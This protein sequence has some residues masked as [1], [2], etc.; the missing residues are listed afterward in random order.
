MCKRAVEAEKITTKQE[1]DEIVEWVATVDEKLV[2]ADKEVSRLR[3]YQIGI[4]KPEEQK[5]QGKELQ[6]EHVHHETRMK[7]QPELKA[8]K[9][10]DNQ[11]HGKLQTVTVAE[12]K[13]PKV[14]ITKFEGSY[15]DWPRFRGQFTELIDKSNVHNMTKF[16]YLR[17]LLLPK[18]CSGVTV[19]WRRL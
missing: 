2:K 17:Q 13:S 10:T 6:F 18:D 12:A 15:Q 19:Y 11:S 5:P 7:F 16:S 1:V 8:A 4:K 9:T 14:E 3:E